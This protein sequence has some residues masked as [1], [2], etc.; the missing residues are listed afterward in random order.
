MVR[1]PVAWTDTGPAA[2]SPKSTA[3]V[4]TNVAS[5]K[6][7]VSSASRALPSRRESLVVSVDRSAVMSAEVKV[8]PSMTIS[9]LTSRV[10]PTAV[11]EPMVSSSSTR[12][13]ANEPVADS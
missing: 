13:P 3:S 11:A 10:R 12:K 2:G 8:L 5:G 7:S 6:A 1:S 9:P 4:S